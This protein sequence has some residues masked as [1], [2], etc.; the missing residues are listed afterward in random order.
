[1]REHFPSVDELGFEGYLVFMGKYAVYILAMEFL[2]EKE[3]VHR[4]EDLAIDLATSAEGVIDVGEAVELFAHGL[5]SRNPRLYSML[6]RHA[7]S[8]MTMIP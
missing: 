3:W 6:R 7:F 5:E 1:M 8:M 4:L 2:D